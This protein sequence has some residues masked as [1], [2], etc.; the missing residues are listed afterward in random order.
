ML[1][2]QKEDTLY[3]S[4]PPGESQA[5]LSL[6]I[7][8]PAQGPPCAECPAWWVSW[9][10]P[11]L[12]SKW[13][14]NSEVIYMAAPAMMSPSHLMLDKEEEGSL[15]QDLATGTRGRGRTPHCQPR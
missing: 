3:L 15:Q 5:W 14:A 12:V 4:R 1:S 8:R 7:P 13:E 2:A 10:F 6:G 9:K 11:R